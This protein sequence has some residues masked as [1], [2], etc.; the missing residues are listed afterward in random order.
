MDVAGGGEAEAAGELCGEVADD[1]AEEVV[2]DDDVEL[3]GVADEL[4]G[5]GVYIK[6]AGIDVGVFEAEDL[7]T[8]CQRS[9][10]KV[11][12]LDLSDMQRGGV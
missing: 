8:R 11:M 6:V 2:G 5:E 7:K 10:A 3:A 9:P 4:H 1:V 12:A